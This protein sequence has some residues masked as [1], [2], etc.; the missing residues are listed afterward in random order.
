L[1]RARRPERNHDDD[2]RKEAG[3]EGEEEKSPDKI[4]DPRIANRSPRKRAVQIAAEDLQIINLTIQ[5][6]GDKEIMQKLGLTEANYRYRLNRIQAIANAAIIAIRV[7]VIAL[8]RKGVMILQKR[9]KMIS[10]GH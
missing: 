6:F 3:E 4:V 8:P 10:V 1:I 5:G 9:R 2:N 7:C